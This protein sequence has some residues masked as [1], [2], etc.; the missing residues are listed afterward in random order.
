M[1]LKFCVLVLCAICSAASVQITPN[2]AVLSVVEGSNLQIN[3]SS[4]NGVAWSSEPP[5]AMAQQ[6][7]Q[8]Q[9]EGSVAGSDNISTLTFSGVQKSNQGKYV[10]KD[11]KT[12]TSV[13]FQLRVFSV[14]T[15][16]ATY[17]YKEDVMLNC[18]V[19]DSNQSF[20]YSWK[21]GEVPVAD[22]KVDSKQEFIQHDNGSLEI[23]HPPRNF[24][25]VYT[26]VAEYE[27]EKG[28][29]DA[30]NIDV[31][32]FAHPKV[33]PFDKS[34]NL[35]QDERLVIECK[36]LGYP[37]PSITWFK[38]NEQIQEVEGSRYKM[39]PA[40][41]YDGMMIERGKLEIESVD[42]DD[43]A[44]YKCMAISNKWREFNSTQV[45]LVRVK[46]KLAALWPFLGIVAEVVVL[47]T[48][49]FIYEK[50]RNK[51]VVIEEDANQDG[52]SP[53]KKAEGV[54]HRGSP[55]NPRA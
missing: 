19:K 16:D 18:Q 45:I 30:I 41:T 46:D 29:K 55:N 15:K 49:I 35:V 36:V 33:I 4:P 39:M 52:A 32:Y 13:N 43:A 50:R 8:S 20:T 44:E 24:A 25:G 9:V 51:D 47:C 23:R 3:C 14:T 10:C 54:R 34:K 22:I 7:S 2:K 12:Q 17:E 48:I 53:E 40:K 28:H 37:K 38:E 42:F 21:K 26:C 31:N 5:S 1:W 11:D 27:V 6:T